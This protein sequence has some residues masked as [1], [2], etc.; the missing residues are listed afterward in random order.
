[1]GDEVQ[2][3]R[4]FLPVLKSGLKRKHAI[5]TTP[6]PIVTRNAY[7][8]LANEEDK[9]EEQRQSKMPKQAT[10]VPPIIMRH[11]S[12]KTLTQELKRM[13]GDEFSINCNLRDTEEFSLKCN[14]IQQYNLVLQKLKADPS[15]P[16]HSYAT[17]EEKQFKVFLSG[18]VGFDI[19]EIMADLVKAGL[20]VT[21]VV[22]FTTQR[23]KSGVFIVLLEKGS[24]TMKDIKEKCRYVLHCCARWSKFTKKRG[25]YLQCH[26]CQSFGHAASKCGYPFRCVKCTTIH[27][28]GE[29]P[30]T[31]R[32]GTATCVNCQ[33]PHAANY[34]GCSVYKEF[35]RQRLQASFTKRF[36][37]HHRQS[38]NEQN[39]QGTGFVP[40]PLPAQNAWQ[41]TAP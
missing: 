2:D 24:T 20:K 11:P 19:D 13:I 26:R 40:A 10:R 25:D 8:A 3:S 15:I 6:P 34:K 5:L 7:G 9:E 33:G 37:K 1:M 30:R 12:L 21:K 36:G 14:T 27:Q 17:E 41:R 18:I 31:T 38:L 28:P 29:F 22:S 23:I 35:K 16:Y 4:G 32:D 39:N